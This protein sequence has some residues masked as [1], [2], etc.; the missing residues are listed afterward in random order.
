[1]GDSAMDTPSAL[2]EDT[3]AWCRKHRR[4]DAPLFVGIF[5]EQD[6]NAAVEDPATEWPAVIELRY[7]AEG[8]SW[9]DQIGH[10]IVKHEPRESE[11]LTLEEEI[12]RDVIV[13]YEKHRQH[14]D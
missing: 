1:M 5:I 14:A 8:A 4:E 2:S 9:S 3:I 12:A 7:S 11:E 13:H 10:F 6:P